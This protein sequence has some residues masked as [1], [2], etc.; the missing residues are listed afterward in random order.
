L[1]HWYQAAKAFSSL[2]FFL[3][4]NGI[5][6][7][8]RGG[9]VQVS[10]GRFVVS[11]LT[12]TRTV[13]AESPTQKTGSRT[14]NAGKTTWRAAVYFPVKIFQGELDALAHQRYAIA[15]RPISGGRLENEGHSM[16]LRWTRHKVVLHSIG[17][18]MPGLGSGLV[19]GFAP[20]GFA[21]VHCNPA[22]AM[23]PRSA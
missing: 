4:G 18:A 8:R 12:Q 3:S 16:P 13:L 10:T 11:L 6:V 21:R 7:T 15:A 20:A 17:F 9:D 5:A 14:A 22:L 1:P 2:A 23:W 19:P